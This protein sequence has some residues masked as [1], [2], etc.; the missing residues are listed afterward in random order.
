[1]SSEVMHGSFT[2]ERNYAAP[3]AKV[4]D[5]F[6]DAATKRRWAVEGP[7]VEVVEHS[8]DFRVGGREKS[9]VRFMAQFEGAPPEGT[10]MGNDSTYLDI[11][12]NQRI[13]SA[14]VMVMGDQRMSASL[15]TVQLFA[16]GKGTRLVLTEQTAYFE[17]AFAREE[18]SSDG[19][20][21]REEGFRQWL[22]RIDSVLSPD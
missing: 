2:I 10:A 1:M 20:K 4:F 6:A 12:P 15:I 22:A 21:L 5:T 14:N 13:V 16:A 3:P 8:L 18:E 17:R 9:R 7:G 11:V 19:P